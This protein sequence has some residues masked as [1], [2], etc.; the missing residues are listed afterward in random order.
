MNWDDNREIAR[1]IADLSTW[2]F[3]EALRALEAGGEA[4]EAAIQLL[5]D[6]ERTNRVLE[7]IRRARREI[8]RYRLGLP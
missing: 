8:R 3:D 6:R 1:R 4:R 2:S 5:A 7:N